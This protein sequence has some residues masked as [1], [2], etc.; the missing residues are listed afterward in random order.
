VPNY[1]I[2][3]LP[4]I[5]MEVDMG[6]LTFRHKYGTKIQSPVFC[7]YIEGAG[8][9][10]LVDTSADAEMATSHRGFPTEKLMTFEE[11]LAGLGLKPDDI[12]VVIQTHLHWDHCANTARCH[13][14]KVLVTEEELRFALSPHP[15]TG[16][17]YK[18]DLFKDLNIVLVNGRYEVAPG[19]ELIPAPGHSAGTQAVAIDTEK[20]KAVLT[21]FC[22][23]MENFEPPEDVKQMMPVITPGTHLDAVEAF[24]SMLRIKGLAD[25]LIPMHEPSFVDVKRIP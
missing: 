3:P 21:G 7:W 25:I 10:I 1:H 14:A 23:V 8:Q 13:N 18:K 4:L 16:P 9:N 19:I 17:S 20:G 12:D 15:L 6:I 2:R 5:R 24:E 11:A 22:C